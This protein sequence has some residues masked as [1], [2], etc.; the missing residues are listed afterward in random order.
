M[1][2]R[3]VGLGAALFL[4]TATVGCRHGAIDRQ[5]DAETVG[6]EGRATVAIVYTRCRGGAPFGSNCGLVVRHTAEESFRDRFRD[7]VCADKSAEECEAAFRRM[8]DAELQQRYYAANWTAVA[9]QCAHS[10]PKCDDPSVY[11][12]LLMRSHNTAIEARFD[13]EQGRIEEER[14]TAHAE[15]HR[16][17]EQTVSEVAFWLLPGRTCRSYPSALS[18]ATNTICSP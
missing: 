12:G 6:A 9:A 10:P 4:G 14:R 11:E 16:R 5:H 7:R 3:I 15:E 2:A 17:T 13:V 18:D 1:F 8:I